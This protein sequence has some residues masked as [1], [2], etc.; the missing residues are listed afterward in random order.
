MCQTLNS[1]WELHSGDPVVG[2]P[3]SSAED[4][5]SIHGQG[6]KIP[7]AMEQTA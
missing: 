6:S 3:P 1:I 2:N 5:G 7:Y 4:A